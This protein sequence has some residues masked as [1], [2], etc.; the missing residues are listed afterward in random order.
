MTKLEVYALQGT[1][2]NDRCR[3]TRE[4]LEEA[5]K[6]MSPILDEHLQYVDKAR[7]DAQERA[8]QIP[9]AAEALEKM[10]QYRKKVLDEQMQGTNALVWSF[11]VETARDLYGSDAV[12]AV[13]KDFSQ[14][15]KAN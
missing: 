2:F 12:D 5:Q 1:P 4:Y 11:A 8:K 10:Y 3:L 7:K 9:A 6:R 14:K 13:L 15:G